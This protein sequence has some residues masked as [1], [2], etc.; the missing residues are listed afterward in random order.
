MVSILLRKTADAG[1]DVD[2]A[3]AAAMLEA[4]GGHIGQALNRLKLFAPAPTG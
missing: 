1:L 3:S 4:T 2:E